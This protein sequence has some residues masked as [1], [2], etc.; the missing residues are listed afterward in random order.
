MASLL[1]GIVRS[2]SFFGALFWNNLSGEYHHGTD[3][4]QK[5]PLIS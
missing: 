3:S 5:S 1:S 4:L 2:S